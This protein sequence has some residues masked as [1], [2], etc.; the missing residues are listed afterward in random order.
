MEAV[1]K[2][3]GLKSPFLWGQKKIGDKLRQKFVSVLRLVS[4]NTTETHQFRSR[5]KPLDVIGALSNLL[6]LWNDV[7]LNNK[8]HLKGDSPCARYFR[9]FQMNLLVVLERMKNLFSSPRCEAY[10][11]RNSKL[12]INIIYIH[13]ELAAIFPGG[14]FNE[15][16]TFAKTDA[17]VWWRSMF[18][19]ELHVRWPEFL[20][21]FATEFQ[22]TDSNMINKLHDTLSFSSEYYVS[23]FS[24]DLFS[25]LF[26]PWH[27]LMQVWTKLVYE[28]PGYM[29]WT[30]FD[31][32]R[33][34]LDRYKLQPGTYAFRMSCTNIGFWSVGSVSQ[35]GAVMQTICR[36]QYLADFLEEGIK[37]K[38][39]LQPVGSRRNTD[40]GELTSNVLKYPVTARKMEDYSSRAS[41][42]ICGICMNNTKNTQLEPCQH[43]ICSSCCKKWMNRSNQCPFCR[44]P[45]CSISTIR[46]E[47]D[48]AETSPS[49]SVPD[50]AAASPHPRS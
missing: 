22:V 17:G 37:K 2:I 14:V 20:Q 24:M 40:L 33:Q 7:M 50:V 32:M 18:N 38:Q 45:V 16:Y 28:H 19:S 5:S 46:L 10:F 4:Q 26:A 47:F 1:I 12:S 11:H 13:A 15:Q 48:D 43:L 39:Y 31:G 41:F 25:R 35:E 21:K 44:R 34:L 42:E 9:D 36:S 27:L 3:S 23:V 6:T 30:T 29:A 8:Q 49:P